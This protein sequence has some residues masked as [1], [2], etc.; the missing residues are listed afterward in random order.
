MKSRD[1][2]R[3]SF[4]TAIIVFSISSLLISSA[5]LNTSINPASLPNVFDVR[6]P[7][8][9]PQGLGLRTLTPAQITALAN[10]EREAGGSVTVQYNGLTATPRHLFSSGRYLSAPSQ[11]PPESIA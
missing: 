4:F 6:G 1:L 5:Q 10:L 3:P 9:V 8:G 2:L 11:V 7:D